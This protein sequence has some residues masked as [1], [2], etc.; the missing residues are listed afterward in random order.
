MQNP[1][2]IDIELMFYCIFLTNRWR[3]QWLRDLNDSFD[4]QNHLSNHAPEVSTLLK[5]RET[6]RNKQAFNT[7]VSRVED[8]FSNEINSLRDFS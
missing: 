7:S 6:L 5:A 1:D 3:W 8:V 4:D 2:G